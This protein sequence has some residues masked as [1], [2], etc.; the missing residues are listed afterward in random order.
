[1]SKWPG[2]PTISCK[3]DLCDVECQRLKEG[4][5]ITEDWL[6][7][8][9]FKW[10]QLDRQPD[11]HWL[12][13]LGDAVRAKDECLTSTED[14]GIEMAPCWFK[15]SYGEDA[16]SLGKWFC[17]FRSDAAGRY[18]RFIHLRHLTEQGEVIRLVEVLTGFPWRPQDHFYGAVCSPASADRHRRDRDRMDRRMREEGYPWSGIEKDNTRGRALPEHLEAHEKAKGRI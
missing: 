12:L 8:V 18:H 4:L 14:L 3:N 17:W 15:N 2:C 6:K 9:G 1:M 5:P 7:S 16:G 10:H 11:K 13:W